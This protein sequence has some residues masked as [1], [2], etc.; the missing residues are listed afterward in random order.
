MKAVEVLDKNTGVVSNIDA[1]AL[2]VAIGIQPQTDIVKGV[3][4]LDEMGFA[5]TDENMMTDIDGVYA[6]GDMRRTPLR[7]IITAAS[8]GAIAATHAA[9][10][11]I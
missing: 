11:I 5:F 6:V 8:D 4:R 7:Q 10:E 2:F 3:I 1:A 9:R